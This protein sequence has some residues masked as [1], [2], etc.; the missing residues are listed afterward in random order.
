M[1]VVLPAATP[2]R[3]RTTPRRPTAGFRDPYLT[4]LVAYIP[5]EIIAAYVAVSGFIKGAPPSVQPTYFWIVAALLLFLTPV[6]ILET[7]QEQG[8]PRPLGQAAAAFVAFAAWVFATGG[9][10]NQFLYDE[11]KNPQ[12]WY[13]PSVGSIVLVLVC[14]CLP[15]LERFVTRTLGG[16]N[17]E[18]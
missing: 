8:K 18:P 5:T 15:M 11:K 2:K 9:P 1:I 14:L 13:Y 4:K 7:A 17:P 6:W 12:G 3:A 16:G 10:F